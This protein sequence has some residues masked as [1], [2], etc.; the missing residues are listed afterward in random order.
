MNI[1]IEITQQE[2]QDLIELLNDMSELCYNQ[3]SA[4]VKVTE[5]EERFQ[6]CLR[7]ARAAT[8]L[9]MKLARC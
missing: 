1:N 5:A 7:Q 8:K 9:T 4:L 6:Y 2:H 3:V